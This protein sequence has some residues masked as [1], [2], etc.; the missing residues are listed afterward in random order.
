MFTVQVTSGFKYAL[1]AVIRPHLV[2]KIAAVLPFLGG[3]ID[4]SN[5]DYGEACDTGAGSL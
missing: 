1:A 3:T 2:R 5:I 4:S